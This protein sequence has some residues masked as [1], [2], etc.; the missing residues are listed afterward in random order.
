MAANSL[1]EAISPTIQ[2]REFLCDIRFVTGNVNLGKGEGGIE[3]QLD[4]L[5]HDN[6][7]NLIV[8]ADKFKVNVLSVLIIAGESDKVAVLKT[9]GTKDLV[10]NGSPIQV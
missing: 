7:K 1:N 3:I 8:M 9:N 2:E 6:T 4:Y 5:F 10:L